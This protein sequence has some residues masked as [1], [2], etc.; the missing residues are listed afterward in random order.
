MTI[1]NTAKFNPITPA[2]AAEIDEMPLLS[3]VLP[4]RFGIS[5]IEYVSA[6]C[7]SCGELLEPDAIRG[8]FENKVHNTTASLTAFGCCLSCHT[9]TPLE[10]KFHDSGKALFKTPTGW[11]ESSWAEIKPDGV[12]S[13]VAG[14]I[15][16][17]WQQL[18]PPILVL[19]AT[20]LWI[21]R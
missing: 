20:V 2:V 13:L 9:I 8:R 12:K 11:S 18:L 14:F 1:E 6:K 17:H 7:A 5:A 19:G 15:K 10:G 4:Y 21:L 3:S 16:G